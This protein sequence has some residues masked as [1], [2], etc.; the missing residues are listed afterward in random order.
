M[1]L[2]ARAWH[3]ARAVDDGDEARFLADQKI[4]DDDLRAGAAEL[5]S[6]QHAVQRGFGVCVARRNDHALARGEPVGLDHDRDFTRPHVVARGLV[7]R[8]CA[9]SR[10]RNAMPSQEVLREGLRAFELCAR[11]ERTEALQ[12]GCLEAIHDAADERYLGAHDRQLD[13]LGARE[14]DQC[15]EVV[16]R[17]RDVAR[18]RFG[19]SAG[20]AGRHEHFRD[21][22]RLRELPGDR[23]L[24]PAAADDQDLHCS[25]PCR[26]W[27]KCRI[28]VKI[29]ASPCSSAA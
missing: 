20:I 3:D 18:L 26:Q 5:A 8:E 2:R 7:F 24:A 22:R 23:M 27:R 10:R 28:P 21:A 9:V 4:L 11:G 12:A 14:L 25:S 19:G 17:Y 6:A 15:R 29:I 1:V 13:P 16:D